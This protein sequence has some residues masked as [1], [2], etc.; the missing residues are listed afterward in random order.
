MKK[1]NAPT[2]VMA[3]EKDCLF[4]GE[5]VIKR[6]KDI[7]PNCITYL[8]KGRGNMSIMTDEEKIIRAFLKSDSFP[9]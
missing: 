1:C 6:A 2:L 4:P 5:S 8:I 7:I 9:M 3:E